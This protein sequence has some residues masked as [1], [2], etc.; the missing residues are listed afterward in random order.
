[1]LDEISCGLRLISVRETAKRLNI[2]RSTLYVYLDKDSS[3][4]KPDLPR[5]VR[6][7]SMVSFI[8]HEIDCYIRGLMQARGGGVGQ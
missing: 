7:G 4:F 1:M 5:P 8:E 3:L 2:G 6:I